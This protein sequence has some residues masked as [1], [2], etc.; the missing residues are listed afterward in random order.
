MVYLVGDTHI[1]IDIGKLNRKNFPQQKYMN[2]NDYVIVL[3]DFGLLWKEDKTYW[4][5]KHILDMKNFTILWL[6]G[7]HE[8]H[9]W[10][11]SLDVKTWKGGKVHYIS[12]NIIHLMRGQIFTIEDCTFFVC[13][14]ASSYDKACRIEN[15]SW[16]REEDI[17]YS[18]CYEA[19]E[20]LD[21][22][23]WNVDFVLT[24]TCPQSLV[25]PM[26]HLNPITCPT[27]SFLD[28]VASQISVNRGWYFG[29]WHQDKSFGKFQC[30]YNE[31]VRVL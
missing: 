1:P 2:R 18:E 15:I 25:M 26:F 7:N 30:L 12:E 8:N 10:L 28:C 5:W 11:N 24:H 31:V 19:T 4:H 29:H 17:S 3:G 21:K 22:Y 23:N 14:G 16:W 13:G 9:H 27:G 6:D 20:N